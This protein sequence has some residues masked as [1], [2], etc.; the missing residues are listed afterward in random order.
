MLPR[1]SVRKPFTV[2]VAVIVVIIL[3]VVSFTNMTTDLMPSMNLPYALIITTDPG[4]G[5]EEVE[6]TVSR[7]VEQAMS[8]IAGIK[9]VS[10]QSS[11]NVSM[12][13]LEFY[14]DTNMDAATIEM[15]ESLDRIKSYFPDGVSSPIILKI[16]PSM[17]PI[18][19]LS[20]SKDGLELTELSQLVDSEILAALES[21]EGV[22]SASA[23]GLVENQIQVIVR[24][25]K[26][27]EVNQKIAEAIEAQ[28]QAALEGIISGISEQ[29]ISSG[30]A[31]PDPQT[32]G[33]TYAATGQPVDLM[34][35]AAEQM[36]ELNGGEENG[37]GAAPSFDITVDMVSGLLQ[38]QNF[39]MPAG[40]V[41]E[42][43]VEY[44]VRV[45][46]KLADINEMRTL[47]VADI[48]VEGVGKIHL[49]DV[50]E[51]IVTDNAGE[52]YARVWSEGSARDAVIITLQKQPAYATSE[53]AHNLT[54][55]ME[56]LS[57][58]YD[59]L[60]LTPL[61]DQG[62]Y[63]DI[64]V[65]SVVNNLLYGGLLAI[66]ILLL[67]LRDIR[68]TIVIAFSIP[69]S[70]MVAVVL[71]YFSG[72]TL[73]IIS[74]SGLAL[75]VGMLVDNSIVVI[76][77][78][79]RMRNDGMSAMKAAIAGA[80]QVSGAI[81]A[82][83]LTTVMVFLPILFITGLA[84]QLFSDMALTIAFSLLA[85]LLIALTLVPTLSSGIFRNM[86]EKEHKVQKKYTD[87]YGRALRFV[88]N[89]KV[90]ALLLALIL[91]VGSVYLSFRNG[92]EL[93]PAMNSDQINVTLSMPSGSQLEDTAEASDK[94]IE[95]IAEID[96][97]DMIGAT[98]GNAMGAMVGLGGGGSAEQ[99]SY[100]VLLKEDREL[101]N[102]QITD[103]IREKTTDVG[104]EVTVSSSNMN[105]S[106][107]SGEGVSVQITGDDLD[108][109]R[110][111]AGDVSAM[112]T[113]LGL[114]DVDDGLGEAAPE[115][116]VVVD[117]DKAIANGLTVATIY[118]DVADRLKT[119]SSTATLTFENT[120]YA[121]YLQKDEPT[122]VTRTDLER[123]TFATPDG[124]EVT[125]SE[126]ADIREGAGL[127]T[128]HREGHK[129]Y[130]TV[131]GQLSE[132]QNVGLVGDEVQA[133][134]DAMAIPDGHT[135]ALSGQNEMIAST[136]DDLFLMLALAIVLIYLVM[137]A[138]FESLLSPFIVM[139]TLPLGFTGG[140]LALLI[141]GKPVS[142]V[143]MVGFVLLAGVI[144]NNGIVFIDYINVLRREGMDKRDAIVKAG[145]VRLRPILMTALTTIVAMSTM[146]VGV[147]M[148]TEMV[149]PLAIVSIGGLTYGTFMTLFVVP[150]IY[151][152]FHR[153]NK[154]L[155][156][157]DAEL[158]ETV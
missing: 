69:I 4:A 27:D 92:T 20:A 54:A 68:P 137:V 109:M 19:A 28:T 112:M 95:R 37:D 22:A 83:T 51:V 15:R 58:K 149:Q 21:V 24:Q 35:L 59:G 45:G 53:V 30:A 25:E 40:T 57:E 140:F 99:V 41:S 39:Q 142:I 63:V 29:L 2:I 156:N 138:Q 147:G 16:N 128:I 71:M 116:R 8:S 124:G 75:G 47:T 80:R 118:M 151:D 85:S 96:G 56:S 12:V 101:S 13:V 105:M 121:L 93:I 65:G 32:G 61:M 104:G 77:S 70:L 11:D 94:L 107:L 74:L 146:S 81:M 38:G 154:T 88:L 145:Q 44:M 76:E 102:A 97:V 14:E 130:I 113:R 5:P 79:Y 52:H 91:L 36:S 131:T 139:F 150:I 64:V 7:S 134:L 100:Y 73:N 120:D 152:A 103:L 108:T 48:P 3:G 122:G 84:K 26:I 17:L 50:A 86:K 158:E 82:S 144:V 127:G 67:F 123:M 34:A 23:S 126:L 89:H 87:L 117:K 72:V 98:M 18:M 31:V 42:D 90:W 1:F 119:L 115:L 125:L 62:E 141:A 153:K 133:E 114:A 10:S 55:K 49:S 33:L 60:H 111:L 157:M 132:G 66:L 136:F 43:G 129:R 110:T 46:D 143:A 78:I 6:L 106:M 9:T 135:V 148:G 155:R